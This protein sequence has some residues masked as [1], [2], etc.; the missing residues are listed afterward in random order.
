[1]NSEVE[2]SCL[3]FHEPQEKSLGTVGITS[4]IRDSLQINFHKFEII[5]ENY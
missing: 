2:Y 4:Y 3:Y 1:M 5:R